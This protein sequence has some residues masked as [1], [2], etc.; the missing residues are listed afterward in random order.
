MDNGGPGIPGFFIFFV[1]LAV[2]IGVG[3]TWYRI[4]TAR[5]IARRTGMDVGDAT[6]VAL[7]NDNGL[8]AAYMRSGMQQPQQRVNQEPLPAEPEAP[9][10]TPE[11]RLADLDNLH[12]AGRITDEEYAAARK[13]IIDSL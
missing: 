4:S 5:S 3:T 8:S 9:P 12:D 2:V 1:I 6:A 7:L 10:R 13:R 11:Q